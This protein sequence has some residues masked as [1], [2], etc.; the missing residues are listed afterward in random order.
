MFTSRSIRWRVLILAQVA[1]TSIGVLLAF[2][3]SSTARALASH[4]TRYDPSTAV[5]VSC[6]VMA[7][8]SQSSGQTS[9]VAL[10]DSNT[11]AL[12]AARNWALTYRDNVCFCAFGSR[13]GYGTSAIIFS[14]GSTYAYALCS[15]D[16]AVQPGECTT[17]WHS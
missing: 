7:N 1:A 11:L 8:N 13:S 6:G 5:D 4:C 12:G 3:A 17:F 9:S 16:T 2:A 14:S 15:W 10:R